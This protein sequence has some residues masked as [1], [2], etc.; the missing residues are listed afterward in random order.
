MFD[1][2]GTARA[3]QP[4]PRMKD[5]VLCGIVAGALVPLGSVIV[6]EVMFVVGWLVT[7][8]RLDFSLEGAVFVAAALATLSALYFRLR[9]SGAESLGMIVLPGPG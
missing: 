9:Y 5:A 4:R 3:R 8:Q 7:E 2:W 1:M 6:A